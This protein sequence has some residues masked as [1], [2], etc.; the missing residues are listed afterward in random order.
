MPYN[1]VGKRN[2]RK[3]LEQKARAHPDKTFLAFE[4]EDENVVLV[5]LC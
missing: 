3:A 5:H 2:L 1:I 4:D